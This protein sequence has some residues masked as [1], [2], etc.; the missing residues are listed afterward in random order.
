MIIDELPN[1]LHIRAFVRVAEHGSVSRASEALYRAQSVVTRS[2]RDLEQRL[3]VPLFERHA[4]GMLLTEYG[5][6]VLPRARRALEELAQ[7]PRLLGNVAGHAAEP[8]YLLN[9]RRLALFIKLCETRHMQTVATTF[10][11][12]QPA[13]STALKVLESGSGCVL[14]ERS[15]RGLQPTR[16]SSDI[17]LP[18]RRALNELRHID[19]DVAALRGSLL[20]AVTIGALPLGRS[21]I[22]PK[23]IIRLTAAHPNIRI[24]TNESPFDLLAT[25]LRA[26]DVDFIFGAL[27][28]HEFASDLQGEELLTEDMVVLARKGHPL[29]GRALDIADLERARWVLPRAGSPARRL[30]DELFAQ[31]GIAAPE[32]VVETGDLAMIRGLLLDSEMIAA[33]SAHQL[34]HE[35]TSGELQQL[36]VQLPRTHRPI[37]LTYR[38]GGLHSPAAKALMAEIRQVINDRSVQANG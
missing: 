13:V 24:A 4:G 7:V 15:S 37:G 32:P 5:K 33:V 38:V 31:L 28:P 3:E 21:S 17:L 9:A 10:G 36:Q 19:G 8:L 22:L 6:H 16:A 12:T 30:L 23:A 29:S 35:I 34:L 27:R 20:G 18:I 2:I 26:G 25:E 11:L 14:F 1:L